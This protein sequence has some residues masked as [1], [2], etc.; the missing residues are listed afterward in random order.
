MMLKNIISLI[1]LIVSVFLSV[2]HGWD[3]I[4]LKPGTESARM[5]S[6]LGIDIGTAKV[7]GVVLIVIAIL[8][9]F[10]QTF[11]IGNVLNAISILLVMSFALK[12]GQYKIALM[13]I[14]FLLIPLVMI[15]LK[16]PFRK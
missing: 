8:L 16:Y 13:E 6:S 9:V 5:M 2:K 14:P 12:N 15:W 10:P 11:F 1:L 7:V 3:S 4:N